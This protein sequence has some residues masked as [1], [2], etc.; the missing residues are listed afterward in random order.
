MHDAFPQKKHRVSRFHFCVNIFS[1][2]GQVSFLF[3]FLPHFLHPFT[4]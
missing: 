4:A 1:A 3:A 2:P